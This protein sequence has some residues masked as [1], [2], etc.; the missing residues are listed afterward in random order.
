M[1]ELNLIKI[2]EALKTIEVQEADPDSVARKTPAD[3][4][5]SLSQ[6]ERD[7]VLKHLKDYKVSLEEQKTFIN[8]QLKAHKN[9]Q[10]AVEIKADDK[11][12]KGY[13]LSFEEKFRQNPP[14]AE[15]RKELETMIEVLKVEYEK[16]FEK[17]YDDFIKQKRLKIIPICVG[18]SEEQHNAFWEKKGADFAELKAYKHRIDKLDPLIK[19]Y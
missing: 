4:N 16:F 17:K 2:A 12:V 15:E 13:K 14:K 1:L 3:A 11:D 10:P 9:S 19:T 5:K 7:K 6:E 18:G 8:A